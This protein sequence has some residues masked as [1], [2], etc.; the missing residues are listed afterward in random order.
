MYSLIKLLHIAA[1][2]VWLGGVGF[3]QFALRPAATALLQPPSRLPLMLAVM[4]RFFV[5]VWCSIAILL[6][7]G[8][9]ML[10]IVGMKAAPLGWHLMLGIGVVMFLIFGHIYFSAFRRLKRAVAAADWPEGGKRV[11]QIARMAGLNFVLGWIAIAAV[12]FLK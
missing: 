3:M 10:A 9:Q 1:A 4:E 5:L 7:T 11:A 12:I 2:I 6:L 8:G